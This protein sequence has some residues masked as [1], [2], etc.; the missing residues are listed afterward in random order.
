MVRNQ[1]TANQISSDVSAIL[2]VATIAQINAAGNATTMRQK[3][4][5]LRS[6]GSLLAATSPAQST[7]AFRIAKPATS[8]ASASQ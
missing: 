4:I 6:S 5:T 7:G 2:T 8:G 1:Y 3:E